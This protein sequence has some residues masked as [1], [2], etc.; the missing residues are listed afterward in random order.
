MSPAQHQV[1]NVVAAPAR[2]TATRG[3]RC[4]RPRQ[5]AL[6]AQNVRMASDSSARANRTVGTERC[7]PTWPPAAT[8]AVSACTGK[9]RGLTRRGS[10]VAGVAAGTA[11][12]AQAPAAGVKAGTA[13][14]A[15][16][17]APGVKAGT[18]TPA[19]A[20]AAEVKAGTA[21]RTQAPDAGVAAGTATPAQAPDAGVAAGT[22][23]GAR[24]SQ[25]L[26]LCSPAWAPGRSRS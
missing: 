26:G 9:T 6:T 5:N 19:Q 12:R 3:Q 17:P 21:A 1:A 18:A 25:R 4:C 24:L 11:A 23:L 16:A 2:L 20:P 14:P 22:A 8:G 7:L 10:P 13:T 15:Q